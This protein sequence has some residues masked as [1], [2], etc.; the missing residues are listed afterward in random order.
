MKPQVME[1]VYQVLYQVI[2]T[3]GLPLTAEEIATCQRL[4]PTTVERALQHLERQGRITRH[5][6]LPRSIR[7][8]EIER[9]WRLEDQVLQG[10]DQFIRHHRRPPLVN[11]L[12]CQLGYAP[13]LIADILF[14]LDTSA[15]VRDAA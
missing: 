10:F 7:L 3:D 11:E 9:R 2:L 8:P 12:A 1:R 5:P 13:P 15:S 14:S 4:K 6:H